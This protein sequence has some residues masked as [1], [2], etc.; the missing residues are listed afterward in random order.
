MFKFAR[1][2]YKMEKYAKLVKQCQFEVEQPGGGQKPTESQDFL[3][4]Y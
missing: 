4:K 3:R 1:A 2:F